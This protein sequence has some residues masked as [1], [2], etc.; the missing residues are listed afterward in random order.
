MLLYSAWSH[1]TSSYIFKDLQCAY[2]KTHNIY[3]QAHAV[4]TEAHAPRAGLIH[5]KYFDY[6]HLL[7]SYAILRACI[8]I[9]YGLDSGPPRLFNRS[10]PAST[11]LFHWISVCFSIK[12]A[13]SYVFQRKSLEQ[14]TQSMLQKH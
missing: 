1:G 3:A 12:T 2:G 13:A 9:G 6:N 7:A 8:W 5:Y 11:W 4:Y 10:K 14:G